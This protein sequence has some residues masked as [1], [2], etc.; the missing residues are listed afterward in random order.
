M[1]ILGR[2]QFGNPILRQPA[3]KIN[4]Q[5][6]GS[7]EI[8][9]L[10]AGMRH[11][12]ITRKLGVAMAAPQVGK[13]IALVV[14]A[15][16]PLAHRQKIEPFDAVLINPEI[17]EQNGRRQSLWEGCISSGRDGR[18]DLFAKVPRYP[19]VKVRYYDEQGKQHHEEFTGFRAQIVQHEVDHLQGILFVDRVKDPKTF[20]TYQ[21]YMKMMRKRLNSREE[22]GV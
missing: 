21:E 7:V 9:E 1:K 11:T 14:V 16:R 6:I 20:I 17:T 5:D 4:P 3:Q 12:L 8:Q 10:I 18:P 15:V 19:K 2:T 22:A 13:S